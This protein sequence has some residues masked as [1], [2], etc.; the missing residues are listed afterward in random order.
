M[1]NRFAG[2]LALIGLAAS[3]AAAGGSRSLTILHHEAIE[4]AEGGADGGK[5]RVSFDAYGRRFE[6]RLEP[7]ERVRR[8]LPR[9]RRDIVPLRG[10]LEGLPGSW[11]RLT[12]GPGGR[13]QG[14]LSDGRDVYAIEPAA[15]V[16]EAAV[17]PLGRAAAGPIVYRLADAVLPL[18][19]AFCAT[20]A[21]GE[22]P[23]AQLAY[24]AV[25]ADRQA[26]EGAASPNRQ[27]TVGIVAD[28]EFAQFFSG[29][30]GSPEQA[31]V[32]RMNIVDGIFS[33]QLGLKIELAT[34]TIFRTESDPFTSMDARELLD[35]VRR[36]RRGS[37]AQLALG[38]THLMTGRDMQGETV[39][40]AFLGSVCRGDAAVSLSEG[41]RS[42]TTAALIA[43]HEI[44]HNF[45][46]P[47][48]GESGA[49]ATTPRTF[50]MSPR[51]NG[52]DRFSDCSVQQMQPALFGG[53]C[54]AELSP[55]D[56]ALE[57]A[58][59][60]VQATA[61]AP[62]TLAFAVRAVGGQRSTAVEAT[63]TLPASL[64]LGSASAQG[65]ACT[66][67]AGTMTCSLG[68]VPAGE[69][70]A[71]QLGLTAAEAGDFTAGVTLASSNDGV[72]SNNAAQ[73]AISV[74]APTSAPPGSNP[75]PAAPTPDPGTQGGSGGGG[76]L[77]GALLGMLALAIAA[78]HRPAR[79]AP[80]RLMRARR[81]GP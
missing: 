44:A 64:A 72:A 46:A 45:N 17:Q 7:N 59:T 62:F 9:A 42:T 8:A 79:R 74:A 10:T 48:D 77:G 55:A 65:G 4:L 81:A 2:A 53:R 80:A 57:L 78:A 16:A 54:L 6:M 61:N 70:R 26:T 63:V 33:A 69:S 52:S 1:F 13:W 49:C 29:G 41:T 12:R 50:L 56:V 71:V 32:A 21:V 24:E 39:G 73:V 37:N 38:L 3:G 15:D 58:A 25:A 67:G 68:D 34:P 14:M 60:N 66:S 43:A 5:A 19:G 35:E 47:H 23:T 27:L 51:L 30:N 36:Y 76:V 20:V 28:R 18:G 75:P 11:V 31:I 40:I 22:Q